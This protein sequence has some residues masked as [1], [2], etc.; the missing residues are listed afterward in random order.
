MSLYIDAQSDR[1]Q[2]ARNFETVA[3]G[4]LDEPPQAATP[5]DI[6]RVMTARRTAR[7]AR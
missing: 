3:S 5:T 7:R 6:V 1:F 4:V 2:A